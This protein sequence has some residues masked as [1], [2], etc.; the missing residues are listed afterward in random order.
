MALIRGLI[1]EETSIQYS[2]VIDNPAK[3]SISRLTSGTEVAATTH[4]GDRNR[5]I[6]IRMFGS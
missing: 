1:L 3:D 5:A 6:Q 2:I 4:A